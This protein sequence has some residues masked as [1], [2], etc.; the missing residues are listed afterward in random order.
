MNDLSRRPD[1]A[2]VGLT[3]PHESAALHV[4]GEALYTDDLVGR[5]RDVLHAHPVQ[6]P[7]AHARVTG[8]R[9]DAAYDVP[10]VVRVLTVEDVPGVN[11]AGVKN[12]EPLFPGEVMYHGQAVSDEWQSLHER[13]RMAPTSGVMR[14]LARRVLRSSTGGFERSG[15]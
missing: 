15:L 12:D 5:T 4:T 10:G 11:D 7:H 9:V 2:A 1:D 3:I 13:S 8:L 14:V 6:A